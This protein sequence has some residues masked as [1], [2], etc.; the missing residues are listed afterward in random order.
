M[1]LMI[2][3]SDKIYSIE[4]FYVKYLREAGVEVN[5][6]TAQRFFYDYYQQ[7]L[8]NKLIFRAGLSGILKQ[9]NE[10]FKKEVEQFK[11]DAIWVFKGM[12]LFPGS[13]KWAKASG[14][15]L[16]N[17]NGDNP[18]LFSGRGS[19]NAHVTNAIP[20]YDLHLTYNA[21]VKKE[22]ESKF[23]I[24]TVIL[25]FGYDMEEAL[26]EKCC[27]QEE[28]MRVCFLGNPDEYRG[29]F[30]Q[31]LADKGIALDLYGNDWKK[32]V[33]HPSVK[34]FEPIYA[35]DCWMVLRRYRVQL[36]LMRP[37]NPDTHNMRSFEL[38]GVGAIQLAPATTDHLHYFKP[39][40]EIFIY[41][42]LEDCV[43]QAGRILAMDKAAV[44][45]VRENA[46]KRS[47]QSGYSYKAR[48]L[49]VL[50]EIK[51]LVS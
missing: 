29:K 45:A 51:K 37:H 30:L 14:I 2:V 1:K 16:L 42:N 12:E 50:E 6:F 13:L 4:N 43:Q 34:I 18:F 27:A 9:I 39:G 22:I 40:E 26:Y 19:G 7:G 5:H 48:S 20:L 8:L 31:Q 25:P 41:H 38:G 3:G 10:R 47:E 28:I 49:Q 46:R 44:D 15:K 24:P 32:F 33:R 17:F 23:A 36:N 35:D 21:A 11:P